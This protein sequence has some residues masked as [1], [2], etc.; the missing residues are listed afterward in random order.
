MSIEL[1]PHIESSLQAD[2]EF[3]ARLLAMLARLGLYQPP[4]ARL[5]QYRME[6]AGKLMAV[7][8]RCE[9]R[10]A[11]QHRFGVSRRTAYR[12]MD[13]ALQTRQLRL[14]GNDS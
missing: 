6:S 7:M 10:E 5:I 8:P 3:S 13:R 14:F 4:R 1:L 9:A 12:L 2:P 11:L